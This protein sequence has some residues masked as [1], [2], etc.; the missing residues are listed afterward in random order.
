MSGVDFRTECPIKQAPFTIDRTHQLFFIGSCFTESVGQRLRRLKFRVCQNPFG[1]VFNP[2]SI[3]NAL[4]RMAHHVP[5]GEAD[6]CAHNDLMV[7][8][9]HH[10]RFSRSTVA[11]TLAAINAEFTEGQQCLQRSSVV[12]ITLGSAWV[13]EHLA[14]GRLV[15]NCH[16]IPSSAFSKRLLGYPETLLILRQIPELLAACGIQAQVVFTVSPVRHLRD[17]LVENQ[18]SKSILVAA[19]QAVADEFPS[20]HYFPAYE[21][22]VDDLRD[23]RFYAADMMHP[24]AQAIDYVFEKFVQTYLG[25]QALGANADF[26]SLA[27]AMEH[28]PMDAESNS[29]QRFVSKQLTL[30]DGL[31]QQHPE[32]DFTTEIRHFESLKMGH[33]S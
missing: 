26:E 29:F 19:A 24:T 30:I 17:G 9:D 1:I 3:Q 32:V 2:F 16:K 18:R 7:S 8:L 6:L 15:A 5:Y 12:F 21:C 25:P 13:Y 20:C 14:S 10:G 23:Y 27:Q 33:R 22:L 11:E 4:V 31:R 28:K